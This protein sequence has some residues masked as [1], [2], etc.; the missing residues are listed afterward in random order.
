MRRIGKSFPVRVVGG[1]FTPDYP[2]SYYDLE[3]EI[4]W[5][6]DNGKSAGAP[7]HLQHDP[8]NPHD[9]NAISVWL[10]LVMLG[11]VPAQK[12]KYL[13][14]LMDAGQDWRAWATKVAISDD[15]PD[16]PGL[17]IRIKRVDRSR[18]ITRSTT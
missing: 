8:E 3:E 13:A 9:P 18:R 1:T 7:L 16:N 11:H 14:P 10:G 4:R 6:E 17:D 2:N 15:N 5:Q 12:A